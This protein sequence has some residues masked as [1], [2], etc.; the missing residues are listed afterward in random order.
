MTVEQNNLKNFCNFFCRMNH[1]ESYMRRIWT[2]LRESEVSNSLT[3]LTCAEFCALRVG[4][5]LNEDLAEVMD[6]YVPRPDEDAECV[7]DCYSIGLLLKQKMPDYQPKT[8][9]S[10]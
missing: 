5:V 9:D 4:D 6:A 3:E 8:Y 2:A 7:P 10:D 1:R